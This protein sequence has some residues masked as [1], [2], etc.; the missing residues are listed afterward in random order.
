MVY[1]LKDIFFRRTGLGTLGN[2]GEEVVKRAGGI[3]AAELGWSSERL[4]SE[5]DRVGQALRL[6]E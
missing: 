5:L 6:P 1:T 3:A 2:P 4:A